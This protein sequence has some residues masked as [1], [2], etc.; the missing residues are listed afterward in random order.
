M[1]LAHGNLGHLYTFQTLTHFASGVVAV[2]G[3]FPENV[4]VSFLGDQGRCPIANQN[5]VW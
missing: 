3:V 2:A 5:Q 1:G 4:K